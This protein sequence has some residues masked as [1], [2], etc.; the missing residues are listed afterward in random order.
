MF[1]QGQLD[2]YGLTAADMETY[3]TSPYIYY[4]DSEST[5]FLVMNPDMETLEGLQKSAAPVNAGNSVNKTV[6]T[7]EAFRKA[8]SFSLDRQSF[9]QQLSPTSG[10][11]KS[12][13]SS[14]IIADPES[15]LSYRATEEGKDAILAFWGLADQ[16]GE[17]KEFATKD[18]AI[19]SITGYDPTGAKDLQIRQVDILSTAIS[20][21]QK[22]SYC[23]G[24]GKVPTWHFT[25]SVTYKLKL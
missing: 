9:N 17:G 2:S 24:C 10:I 16:V 1:E 4:N 18:E 20:V 12:L 25:I 11:A 3:I 7:L 19:A 22:D 23:Y 14:M 5:W 21:T 13:L 15:G 8:L 6:L